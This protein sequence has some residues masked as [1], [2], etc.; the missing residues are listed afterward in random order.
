MPT[1]SRVDADGVK[2]GVWVHNRRLDY[3]KKKLSKEHT[4]ALEA[5]PEWT[6]T[7]E[8]QTA[9]FEEAFELLKEFIAEE[10]HLPTASERGPEPEKVNPGLWAVR[11][12]MDKRGGKLSEEKVKALE[13]VPGWVWNPSRSPPKTRG[14]S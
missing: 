4:E 5:V 2:L 14:S 11:R 12:R 8:V 3:S 6:W 13:E 9:S 1:R 7:S 10:G